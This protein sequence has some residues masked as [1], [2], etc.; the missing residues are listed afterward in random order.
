MASPSVSGPFRK[1]C[2]IGK[3]HGRIWGCWPEVSW[4]FFIIF[5]VE[6]VALLIP[7]AWPPLSSL[8]GKKRMHWVS[9][10]NESVAWNYFA[11]EMWGVFKDVFLKYKYSVLY[12]SFVLRFEWLASYLIFLD[13]LKFPL[14][15]QDVGRSQTCLTTR[16]SIPQQPIHPE[17][18]L[19]P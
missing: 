12:L 7:R 2:L 14:S 6:M 3:E 16:N 8:E 4:S 9:T 10:G 5:V 18:C 19:A 15:Y 1:S 11:N 17:S 13:H